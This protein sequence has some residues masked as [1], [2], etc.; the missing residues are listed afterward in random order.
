MGGWM[1]RNLTL[2]AMIAAVSV[3][4]WLS[5]GAE[6]GV[7]VGGG[8]VRVG[9]GGSKVGVGGGGVRVG[10][11]GVRVTG[12]RPN[13][14]LTYPGSHWVC[15][16]YGWGYPCFGFDGY[17][18]GYGS[19]WGYRTYQGPPLLEIV[20]RVDPAAA[21]TEGM[22][23][24]P[25]PDQGLVA[26]VNRDYPRAVVIFAQR[27]ADES[28]ASDRRLQALSLIGARRFAEGAKLM[29]EAYEAEA[30]LAE[31]PLD[32]GTMV[33][34]SMEWRRLVTAMVRFAHRENSADAWFTV[35]VLMQA[36]G[37]HDWARRMFERSED[38]R[39]RSDSKG[40]E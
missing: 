7:R 26:L 15:P 3:G 38:R 39:E 16:P 5:A 32:G 19:Y 23:L 35:G 40:S 18:W 17:G 37:R 13:Q 28:K 36:E 11:G 27:F 33:R 4:G 24:P 14:I 31:V 25:L 12:S 30:S 9:G 1:G 21:G 29:R 8:G 6:A 22:P 10:G 20:R 34:G 2:G